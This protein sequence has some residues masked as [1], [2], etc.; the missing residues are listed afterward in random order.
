MP[1]YHR[2][3]C[4]TPTY[5]R[6]IASRDSKVAFDKKANWVMDLNGSTITEVNGVVCRGGAERSPGFCRYIQEINWVQIGC[7][8][9]VR[10]FDDSA[11]LFEFAGFW[12]RC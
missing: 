7:I 8:F 10:L 9:Y 4:P 3:G 6:S 12:W 11:T 1:L 2:V 5:K